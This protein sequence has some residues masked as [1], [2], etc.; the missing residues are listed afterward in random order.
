MRQ[1]PLLLS[2]LLWTR[3]P[4]T[5]RELRTLIEGPLMAGMLLPI[6]ISYLISFAEPIQW[7]IHGLQQLKKR[8]NLR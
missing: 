6:W 8:G 5:A 2:L 3:L 1:E 4:L 7:M